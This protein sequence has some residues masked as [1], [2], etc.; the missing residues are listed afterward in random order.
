MLRTLKL[1]SSTGLPP[2]LRP[3]PMSSLRQLDEQRGPGSVPTTVSSGWIFSKHKVG[4]KHVLSFIKLWLYMVI[5]GYIWLYMVIYG[6]I[7]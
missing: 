2:Q 1:H 7:W 4:R 6:Y 5:Y 3:A